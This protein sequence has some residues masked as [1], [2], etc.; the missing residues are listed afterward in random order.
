MKNLWRNSAIFN[1]ENHDTLQF[2]RWIF[3]NL[4]HFKNSHPFR[5]SSYGRDFFERNIDGLGFTKG[6]KCSDAHNFQKLNNLFTKLLELNFYQEGKKS[7]NKLV[8][9]EVNKNN[10]DKVFGLMF[11]KNHR[12]LNKNLHVFFSEHDS[13]FNFRRCLSS[14]LSQNV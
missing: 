1:I 10:S 13:K 9:V 7:K 12:V 5:L 2:S 6:L 4:H 3:G 11:Y 8:A 14:Y